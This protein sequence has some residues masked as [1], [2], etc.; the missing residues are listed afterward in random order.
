MND[1][2]EHIGVLATEHSAPFYQRF[3]FELEDT[4]QLDPFADYH[5]HRLSMPY[6]AHI[7]Q[8]AD[9]L[10]DTLTQVSFKFTFQDDPFAGG[11]ASD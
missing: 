1:P 4:P 3:G 10:L 11:E 7:G 9:E 5:I 2:V 6:A 8:S